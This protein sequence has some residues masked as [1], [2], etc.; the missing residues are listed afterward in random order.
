MTKTVKITLEGQDELHRVLSGLSHLME[1]HLLLK[2][3][4]KTDIK[5]DKA[6]TEFNSIHELFKRLRRVTLTLFL[7]STLSLAADFDP[8]FKSS[9]EWQPPVPREVS[10]NYCD[11]IGKSFVKATVTKKGKARK[12]Y[13]RK[14]SVRLAGCQDYKGC[15]TVLKGM[16]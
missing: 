9:T 12:A 4:A 5:A 13:C 3:K 6:Q 10:K 14:K 16:N 15:Y 1:F 11:S 8:A 2:N 7:F